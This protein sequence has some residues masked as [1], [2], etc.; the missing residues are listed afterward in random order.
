MKIFSLQTKKHLVGWSVVW[1]LF[2]NFV[3]KLVTY[4]KDT[5]N[6][7]VMDTCTKIE[8]Y[9]YPWRYYETGGKYEV[10]LSNFNIYFWL[11][12]SLII[13]SLIRYFKYHR[14]ISV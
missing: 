6:P 7:W 12:V 13:L 9:G 5:C 4:R 3:A 11:F 14:G 10:E 2:I 1:G 8:S